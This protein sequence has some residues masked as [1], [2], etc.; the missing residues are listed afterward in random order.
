M[1][2]RKTPQRK[3]TRRGFGC[4]NKNKNIT[5]YYCNL[6][7]FKG[8]QTS[9]REIIT[10]LQPEIIMFAETKLSTGNLLE[11]LFP[12]FKICPRSTKVGKCGIA[13]GVKLNTFQS[14]LDVTE[15]ELHDILVI[16]IG[17]D[18]QHPCYPRIR[19]SRERT[20]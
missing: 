14:A 3:K 10:K 7:G 12:E 20:C 8:K 18:S 1:S 16:R 4:R 13:V 17:M 6:N 2:L 5:I 19:T 15:S 9:L 11:K